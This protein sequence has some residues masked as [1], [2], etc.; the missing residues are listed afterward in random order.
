[1]IIN[2]SNIE[3]L[4]SK[5]DAGASEVNQVIMPMPFWLADNSKSDFN[6]PP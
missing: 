2:Y 1:M 6:Y 5:D 4:S 3:G